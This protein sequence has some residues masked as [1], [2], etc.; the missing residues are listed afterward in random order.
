M[1]EIDPA[2][3][4]QLASNLARL[5]DEIQTVAA[6]AGRD[7][8]ELNLI[9]VTKSFPASDMVALHQLGVRD[10][11]ESKDQ[12]VRKKLP[13]PVELDYRIHFIGQLQRNKLKSIISYSDLLHSVDR[14]ELIESLAQFKNAGLAIPQIMLQ[15]DLA[16]RANSGRGGAA[17]DALLQLG[18]LAQLHQ[19]SVVGLMAVA[20]LDELPAAAFSRFDQIAA[21]F[22]EYFPAAKYRSIGM[23][24]DWQHAIEYGATHL[25]I[26]AA[27]LGNRG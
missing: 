2:R 18:E 20:P 23:S 22:C 13:L 24:G 21:G 8:A 19:I 16:D 1:V 17:A 14:S 9:A 7:V 3:L 15:V 11:G 10:F 6:N 27:L 4:S 26:G 25:R 12:E 5:K